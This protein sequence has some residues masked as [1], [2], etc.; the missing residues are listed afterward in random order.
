MASELQ[1]NI[2][3]TFT[4]NFWEKLSSNVE[5]VEPFKNALQ[6]KIEKMGLSKDQIYNADETGLLEMPSAQNRKQF[7]DEKWKKQE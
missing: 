5:G 1:K 3:Y 7:Q 4:N 2:W 6:Q